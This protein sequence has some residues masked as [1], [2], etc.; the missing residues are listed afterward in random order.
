MKHENK[1]N[2][3][4]LLKAIATPS[5][6]KTLSEDQ[7]WLL[8]QLT[9]I[10]RGKNHW[11]K[12]KIPALNGL[13]KKKAVPGTDLESTIKRMQL[14]R[15]VTEA[16]A[17]TSGF[18]N[19]YS[20]YRRSSRGWCSTNIKQLRA[21]L[22]ATIRLGSND[23]ARFKLASQIEQLPPV[24]TPSG[25]RAMKAGNLLTPLIA[26][27]DNKRHFPIVERGTPR[28]T[29]AKEIGSFEEQPA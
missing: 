4:S 1:S 15:P 3:A 29:G 9:W 28:Q 21:I 8:L 2:T 13:F 5:R 16:A 14:P 22:S 24:P 25:R 6:I 11:K 10:T 18:V 7:A 19:V 20:A 23:D 27:L 26:C 17:K 12:L